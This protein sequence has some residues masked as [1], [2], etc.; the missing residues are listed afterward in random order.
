MLWVCC[1]VGF[2]TGRLDFRSSTAFASA[3]A[4]SVIEVMWLAVVEMV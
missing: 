4:D 3:L 2:G 1:W